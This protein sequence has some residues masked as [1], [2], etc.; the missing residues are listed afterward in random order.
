M[1]EKRQPNIYKHTYYIPLRKSKRAIKKRWPPRREWSRAANSCRAR[2]LHKICIFDR[3]R[4]WSA[5]ATS[6][7]LCVCKVRWVSERKFEATPAARASTQS[8]AIGDLGVCV[9][10]KLSF[11]QSHLTPPNTGVVL[12][13]SRTHTHTLG[14][15]ILNGC[16]LVPKLFWRT[17]NIKHILLSL[18]ICQSN[19][20]AKI[21]LN[22]YLYYY[23][24]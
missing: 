8:Y 24:G 9:C 3:Q 4:S 23:R 16:P 22:I 12:F 5:L 11:C 19:I 10:A 15:S 7:W 21:L 18:F 2:H 6:G 13:L 20:I 1:L 17:M 14:I